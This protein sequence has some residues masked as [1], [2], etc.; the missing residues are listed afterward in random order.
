MA[1]AFGS[2]LALVADAI[3]ADL[4]GRLS[5]SIGE[6]VLLGRDAA[7]GST[8]E[9]FGALGL[10]A[11][12]ACFAFGRR[13]RSSESAPD[14]EQR[15]AT[16][17]RRYVRPVAW[18]AVA[19]VALGMVAGWAMLGD[20]LRWRTRELA[21]LTAVA[22]VWDLRVCR[23]A[24]DS[25]VAFERS[26]GLRIVAG[27]Y[28]ADADGSRPGIV[29]VHGNTPLGHRLQFYGVL[30]SRLAARGYD[31]LA[32][33]RTGYGRSDDPFRRGSV[34][35]LDHT[36]DVRAAMDF[37]TGLDGVADRVHL[38]GHSGGAVS[39][40]DTG[41]RDPAIGSVVAIGPPRRDTERM[42]EPEG[43]AYFWR[44]AQRTHRRVYGHD[45]PSW[46]SQEVWLA[47]EFASDIANHLPELSR[48]CH[49]PLLLID[50]EREPEADKRY[51]ARYADRIAEPKKYVTIERSD[52]YGN[53]VNFFWTVY[54][55]RVVG[56]TVDVIDSWLRRGGD[57]ESACR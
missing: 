31:V 33:D 7:Y 4:D 14:D 9:M 47:R 18:G 50:G 29:L 56:R 48:R 45:L 46:F 51:L 13:R 19:V 24:A 41:F 55:A 10:L 22:P 35:A 16:R 43:R 3:A 34:D 40:F 57:G 21:E 53:T 23:C 54:D 15:P 38:I 52:H 11:P 27:L 42:L 6:A 20:D 30:A 28:R 32:I 8:A 49:A 12:A 1:T 39:V 2:V 26:D 44:R 36:R 37:L 25:T 17:R 5:I